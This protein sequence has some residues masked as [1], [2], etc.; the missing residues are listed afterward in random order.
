MVARLRASSPESREELI[1]HLEQIL[2][3][4]R[5]SEKGVSK[6]AIAFPK[7]AGASNEV[8]MIEEYNDQLALQSHM[9]TQP[10]Q[11][12]LT[13]FSS[14]TLLQSSPEIYSLEEIA[15]VMN[16]SRRNG[17]GSTILFSL[18]SIPAGGIDRLQGDLE[19]IRNLNDGVFLGIYGETSTPDSVYSIEMYDTPTARGSPSTIHSQ[20]GMETSKSHVLQLADGFLARDQA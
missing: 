3:F 10:V 6:Y 7:N 17:R 2:E 20:L 14:G 1:K 18:A 9:A 11:Q 12:L 15:A 4:V 16:G 13:L 19:R 5:A 8:Y